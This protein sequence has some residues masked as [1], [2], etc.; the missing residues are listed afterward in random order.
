MTAAFLQNSPDLQIVPTGHADAVRIIVLTDDARK[1]L[2]LDNIVA[3]GGSVTLATTDANR[4]IER[5]EH[6]GLIV[7]NGPEPAVRVV[8]GAGRPATVDSYATLY[9]VDPDGTII[10]SEFSETF[11]IADS[12]VAHWTSPGT[13]TSVT[14][15]LPRQPGE[16]AKQA[17]VFLMDQLLKPVNPRQSDQ[18][19]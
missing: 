3:V 5:A 12:R 19:S 14:V 15:R 7:S 10:R 1:Y 16:A 8:D 18:S 13:H 6:I 17:I 11:G 9:I 2:M 4:L